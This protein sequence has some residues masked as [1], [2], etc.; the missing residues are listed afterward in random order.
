MATKKGMRDRDAMVM[1]DGEIECSFFVPLMFGGS[2]A[3]TEGE[4]E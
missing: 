1:T 4:E 2:E 3:E